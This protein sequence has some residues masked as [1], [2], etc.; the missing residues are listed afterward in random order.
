M[1]TW[2]LNDHLITEWSLD[3][4][5]TTWPLGDHLTTEWTTG[6]PLDQQ[7]TTE[8]PLDHRVT[9]EWPLKSMS[10]WVTT[11]PPSDH[12]T[13]GWPLSDHLTT[14]WPLEAR[15]TTWPTSDHLTT[16]WPPSDHL[17][18]EWLLDQYI[19]NGQTWQFTTTRAEASALQ[20]LVLKWGSKMCQ[21]LKMSNF[22]VAFGMVKGQSILFWVTFRYPR[23]PPTSIGQVPVLRAVCFVCLFVDA[24]T[25]TVFEISHPN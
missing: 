12:L 11:Q 7:V 24:A 16:E 23:W 18:T 6:W 13:T 15:V 9:T 5:V 21:S 25:A 14:G 17:T 1:A 4:W 3:H 19:S 2:P 10:H 22:V 8:W 20:A